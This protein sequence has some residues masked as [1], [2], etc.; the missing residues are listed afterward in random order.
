MLLVYAREAQPEEPSVAYVPQEASS[1][2][3]LSPRR[4]SLLLLR[5]QLDSGALALHF[6]V[7]RCS[8]VDDR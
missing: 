8:I 7:S 4:Q 6:E 2:E 1:A 3:E 5:E